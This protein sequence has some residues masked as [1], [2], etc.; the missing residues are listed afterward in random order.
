MWVTVPHYLLLRLAQ[1]QL[2]SATFF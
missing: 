1:L 2:F